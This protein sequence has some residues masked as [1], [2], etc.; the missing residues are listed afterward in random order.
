MNVNLN[1]C[2]SD[3]DTFPLLNSNSKEFDIIPSYSFMKE[4]NDVF[5][6]K[7]DIDL[8]KNYRSEIIPSLFKE[9]T[10][11]QKKNQKM[12]RISSKVMVISL[13]I[14]IQIIKKRQNLSK[15]K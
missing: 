3:D 4:F 1:N 10:K 14:L 5:E 8:H 2:F 12:I 9:N 15:L 11:K 7:Y 13:L 6:P